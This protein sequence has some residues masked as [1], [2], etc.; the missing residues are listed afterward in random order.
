MDVADVDG[1]TR[2]GRHTDPEGDDHED[3]ARVGRGGRPMSSLSCAARWSAAHPWRTILVWLALGLPVAVAGGF[4][5]FA[6]STDDT[7]P[8]LPGDAALARLDH[9]LGAGGPGTPATRTADR[10]ERA[11]PSR[12]ADPQPQGP[13][14][15][16][17]AR[18]GSTVASRP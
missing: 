14:Y 11:L 5:Q 15:G 3:H 4:G 1:L 16:R 10:I 13:S 12:A 7:A 18:R 2:D 9:E 6:V 17:R 8:F